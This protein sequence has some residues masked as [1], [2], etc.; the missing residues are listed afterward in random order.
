MIT[1]PGIGSGI[2]IQSIVTRLMEIE[3]TP[4]NALDK[5]K[6]ELNA[7]VSAYGSIKSALATF[8]TS[9]KSLNS[10]DKYKQKKVDTSDA[11][12]LKASAGTNAAAG[13]YSVEVKQLA[14]S[15]KLASA[16]FATDKEIVGTGDLVIQFGSYDG[17]SFT[18]N[19]DKETQ[20]ISIGASNASLA[21]VRDAI[22]NAEIGVTASLLNDGTGYRLVLKSDDTGLVNSMKITVNGDGDGNNLDNAGLSR[23][24][25]DPAVPVGQIDSGRN[26]IENVAAKN[27]IIKVDGIDNINKSSNVISDVIE[28]VTLNLTK[29]HAANSSVTVTVSADKDKIKEAIESFVKSYNDVNKVVK[30][31]TGFDPVTK[32]GGVL[33]GDYFAVSVKNGISRT[34][35]KTIQGL[36]G[37]YSFLGQIGVSIQRDGQLAVNTAKLDEALS[38]NVDDIATLFAAVGRTDDS[39]LQ[40][41]SATSKTLAGV[42]ALTVSQ[43]PEKARVLG[44]AAGGLASTNGTFNTAVTIDGTNDTLSLSIDGTASG[45]ITLTNGTYTSVSALLAEIQSKINGDT[46]LKAAGKGVDVSFDSNTSQIA[47]TSKSYGA[48]SSITIN[49]IAGA[50]LGLAA[51]LTDTGA[52][53]IGTI[54]GSAAVSLGNYLVGA[55]GTAAEGLQIRV[56]GGA[57]GARGNVYYSHGYAFELDQATQVLL[58]DTGPLEIRSEGLRARIETIE[59]REDSLNLRLELVEKRLLAQF[60]A[61]DAIVAQMRATSDYL[62]RQL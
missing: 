18:A 28:G 27:A 62:S 29:E 30:D 52:D 57:L 31:L 13:S 44:N 55:T 9:M 47:L 23:L 1:S 51:G 53:A 58:D 8:Q 32:I 54:G 49:S 33:Q 48:S 16:A 24:A 20:T 15:Q 7:E 25:F 36:T 17:S 5:Q 46:A 11:D 40:F 21:G 43:L 22:N 26:L 60:N 19:T 59:K 6:R 39:L 50:T 38:G 14:Q 35:T 56:D 10:L 4:L 45:T 61:M 37:T 42:Y 41:G 2:D 12:Y 34:L 3:R